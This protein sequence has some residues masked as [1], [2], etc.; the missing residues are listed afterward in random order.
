[1]INGKSTKN[2]SLIARITIFTFI[3]VSAGILLRLYMEKLNYLYLIISLIIIVGSILLLNY[4]KFRINKNEFPIEL[5]NYIYFVSVLVGFGGWVV[6]LTIFLAFPFLK[7]INTSKNNSERP[8]EINKMHSTLILLEDT[9]KFIIFIAICE[10]LAYWST[11]IILNFFGIDYYLLFY[12]AYSLLIEVIV[13]LLKTWKYEGLIKSIIAEI[14]IIGILIFLSILNIIAIIA[15]M[16]I[17]IINSLFWQNILIF[18]FITLILFSY[19]QFQKLKFAKQFPPL[20]LQV[21]FIQITLIIWIL[22]F[23]IMLFATFIYYCGGILLA[24]ALFYIWML[25]QTNKIKE[26]R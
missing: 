14:S 11:N 8:K 3:L 9:T 2:A 1:M 4:S 5:N 18:I 6:L 20:F 13:F 7:I 10:Q 19:K 21:I 23:F 16:Y 22:E 25:K 15:M 12:I 24:F 17:S 26:N